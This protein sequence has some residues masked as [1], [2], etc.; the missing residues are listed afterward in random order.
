[1][2]ALAN[3]ARWTAGSMQRYE[4]VHNEN[5]ARPDRGGLGFDEVLADV[6]TVASG[7][8]EPVDL[9]DAMRVLPRFRGRLG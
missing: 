7:G 8:V 5:G 2:T 9:S 6:G 1:M 3:L 4:Q